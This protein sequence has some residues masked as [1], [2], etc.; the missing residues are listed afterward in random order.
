M[1]Q[2]TLCALARMKSAQDFHFILIQSLPTLYISES[3]INIII[4]LNFYFHTSFWC[5][6]RFY[7][8]FLRRFRFL[9][10]L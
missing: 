6:E 3:C 7:K 8:G 10:F 5:L 1:K 2:L 9:H 4:N